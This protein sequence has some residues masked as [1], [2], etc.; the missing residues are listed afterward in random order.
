M[1]RLDVAAGHC[2]KSEG[3]NK[4]KTELLN[5]KQTRGGLRYIANSAAKKHGG[6]NPHTILIARSALKL[7]RDAN[8]IEAREKKLRNAVFKLCGHLPGVS[9]EEMLAMVKKELKKLK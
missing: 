4:M 6:F 1:R 3:T 9:D 7:L 5:K 8:I 2:G